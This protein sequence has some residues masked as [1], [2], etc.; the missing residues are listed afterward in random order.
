[1]SNKILIIWEIKILNLVVSATDGAMRLA[2]IQGEE[3]STDAL[4]QG[5]HQPILHGLDHPEAVPV[6]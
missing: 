2:K 3:A 4:Y 6:A 5:D 1:M